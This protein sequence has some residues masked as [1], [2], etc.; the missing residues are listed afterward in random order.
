[1]KRFFALYAKVF[2]VVFM[3]L[4]LLAACGNSGTSRRS[5]SARALDRDTSYAMGM[6]TANMMTE[7][8]RFP[9]M[10]YDYD[11]FRDGFRA[12][13]EAAET[14]LT[15]DEAMERLNA[16]FARIQ[17]E[18]EE[19]FWLEGE[20]NREEGEAF[21]AENGARSGVT[22]TASG[23]QYEIIYR[24]NGE[25]P[26][27]EDDVLI[28]YEGKFINGDIYAS[29]FEQGTPVEL[30]LLSLGSILPGWS[31]G[32]QLMSE[33]STFRFVIPSELA[34]GEGIPGQ[35]PAHATL[36]FTVELIR[37]IRE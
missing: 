5:S 6:F 15:M 12:Y 14:R 10:T 28:H 4:F 11:A 9:E 18:E 29:T 2:A 25:R 36:I 3:C 30:N 37:I 7:M 8:M 23:L 21:L 26:G 20:R 19:E 35:F 16:F 32:V 34:Y 1:M 24:G 17:R 31:E 27:P 22:T 13:N 33:G